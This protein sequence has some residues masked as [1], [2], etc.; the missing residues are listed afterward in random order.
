M[1]TGVGREAM[2]A[3]MKLQAF[4]TFQIDGKQKRFF[5]KSTFYCS[6]PNGKKKKRNWLCYSPSTDKAF[7]F[8]CK[9]FSPEDST[10]SRSGFC[11][12][13]NATQRMVAH[14]KSSKAHGDATLTLCRRAKASC[15][16]NLLLT[17]QCQAEGNLC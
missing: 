15:C 6:Q 13:K 2:T 4:I 11:N 12:W 5:R 7:C 16:V 3:S 1:I 8:Q 9:L 14:E 10:F 17:E